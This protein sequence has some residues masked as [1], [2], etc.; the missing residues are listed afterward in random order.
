MNSVVLDSSAAIALVLPDEA[1]SDVQAFFDGL[2]PG[3][4]SIL[5]PALWWY[6]CAN[7]LLTAV[8]RDRL[9]AADAREAMFLLWRLPRRTQGASSPVDA[10]HLFHLGLGHRLTTYDAAYL[11]LAELTGATLLTLDQLLGRAARSLGVA[12]ALV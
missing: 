7:V 12:V 2:D 3:T 4:T 11:A 10:L 5:V 9:T 8:R 1:S 6:E